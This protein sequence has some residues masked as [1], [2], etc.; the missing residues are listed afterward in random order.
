MKG[1]ERRA[2]Q[3]DKDEVAVMSRLVK[4]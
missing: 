4:Q 2:D 1:L 3:K